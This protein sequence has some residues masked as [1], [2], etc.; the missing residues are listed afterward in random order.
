V[1]SFS[2]RNEEYYFTDFR[3]GSFNTN[4]ELYDF[5]EFIY[6]RGYY[7]PKNRKWALISPYFQKKRKLFE[8]KFMQNKN[9]KSG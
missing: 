6:K 7:F 8:E 2:S 3:F 4:E 1:K 9:F 5:I